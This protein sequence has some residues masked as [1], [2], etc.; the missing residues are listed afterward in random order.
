[1]EAE[2]REQVVEEREQ[3]AAECAEEM[4]DTRK[5]NKVA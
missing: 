3:L 4:L 1:M 5:E 2:E